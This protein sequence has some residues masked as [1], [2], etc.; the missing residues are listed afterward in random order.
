MMMV[1]TM[2]HDAVQRRIPQAVGLAL[3]DADTMPSHVCLLGRVELNVG[4]TKFFPMK[5]R[6]T[7]AAKKPRVPQYPIDTP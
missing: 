2:G 6:G 3:L 1:L 4:Q 7:H 5:E